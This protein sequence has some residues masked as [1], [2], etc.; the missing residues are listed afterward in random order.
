MKKLLSSLFGLAFLFQV[1]VQ[2]QQILSVTS[3]QLPP[4]NDVNQLIKDHLTGAGIEL[5]DIQYNGDLSAAGYFTD[6]DSSIG[7]NRGLVITTGFSTTVGELGQTFTTSGNTGGSVQPNLEA[8]AT[9]SLYNVASFKITFKPFSDSIR[10]RYV[11]ASEEYPEYACTVFNDVF[12]FFLTGPNPNGADY[13]GENIAL[14][15][16]TFLPV[17]INN[18][19]PYN[20]NFNSCP[21]LYEQYYHDNNGSNEQ[22]AYDGFTDVFVAEAKVTPC[23][24]YEMIIAIADVGDAAYDTGVFLEAKSLESAVEVTSSLEVGNDVIPEIAVADTITFSFGQ[25]DVNLMPLQIKLEGTATNGIDYEA[26]NPITFVNGP[27]ETVQFVIQPLSDSL[28]EGLETVVFNVCGTAANACFT[29]KFTLNIVDPDSLYSS[30]EVVFITQGG[31]TELSIDPTQLSN[32]SWSFSNN[33]PVNIPENG[34]MSSASIQVETPFGNLDDLHMLQ[35][36]CLNINHA[37]AEDLK[38]YL[39]APDQRFVELSTENGGSG[40][41]YTNTCF[42]PAAT[43]EIRGGFPF[44]PAF[45]TPFTGTFQPEGDW[46]DILGSPIT[47]TWSIGALDVQN[48]ITG[49]LTDWNITFATFE[50]GSFHYLWNTGD[51][52]ATLMV[53]APGEYTVTV[54]NQVGAFTKTFTVET[55]NVGVKNPETADEVFHLFPNPSTGES[56]LILDQNVHVNAL[57]VYDLNGSLQLSQNTVGPIQGLSALPTGVYIV[58]LEC[59]EGNFVQKLIRR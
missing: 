16:N 10:F 50:L 37:Y 15:P 51:T 20:A 21:P 2:A 41:N 11:F 35:S 43:A 6:G 26:V 3:A 33:T 27:G 28:T 25:V 29:Q 8:I 55:G 30:D 1:N 40:N 52:S 18:I 36:V 31:S 24:T 22:P 54:S 38:L 39:F 17:S 13:A 32:K 57:K 34:T 23:E 5:L 9:S 48:N 7:I 47:G 49:T 4:Y 42:S 56:T 19:H 45:M 59:T 53:N 46:N 44:A 12:G 58:T 14:I